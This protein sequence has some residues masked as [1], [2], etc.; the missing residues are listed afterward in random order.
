MSTTSEF[1]S[2]TEIEQNYQPDKNKSSNIMTVYEKTNL[3]GLRLEQLAMGAP[4]LLDDDDLQKCENIH[5]VAEKELEL[6]LLPYMV[7]RNLGNNT[8]EVWKI[9]DMF[10]P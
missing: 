4:S 8:K 3:I 7:Q 6:K 1:S 5:Q 9:R 2:F 10:I